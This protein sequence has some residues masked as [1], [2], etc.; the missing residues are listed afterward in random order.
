MERVATDLILLRV[1]ILPTKGW[2]TMNNMREAKNSAEN[3]L[4]ENGSL[5]LQSQRQY[6]GPYTAGIP[7]RLYGNITFNYTSAAVITI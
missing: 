5:V 6:A 4:L 7:L 1:K 3:V 2:Q